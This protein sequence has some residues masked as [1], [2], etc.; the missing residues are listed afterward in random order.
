MVGDSV[1]IC[2]VGG[3]VG[4]LVVGEGVGNLVDGR[5]V[6]DLEAVG[7]FLVVDASPRL[8]FI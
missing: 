6:G 8:S 4:L 1:G 2:V 3:G 7:F 5:G